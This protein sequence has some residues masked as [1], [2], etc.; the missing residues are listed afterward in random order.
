MVKPPDLVAALKGASGNP[1]YEPELPPPTPTRVLP[2]SRRGKK[3]ITGHFDPAVGK[4][5]K[6]LALDRNTTVQA[7]L[8]EALNDLLSKYGRLPLA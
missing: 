6:Q 5:L 4:Q 3:A 1:L 8:Q 7:L 2:P